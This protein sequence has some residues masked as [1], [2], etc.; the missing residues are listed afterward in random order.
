VNG[1]HPLFLSLPL[2]IRCCCC[3]PSSPHTHRCH[4][5]T[6]GTYLAPYMDHVN[7]ILN[8]SRRSPLGQV[9]PDNQQR[10]LQHQ[11]HLLLP[12]VLLHQVG[13][14][15]AKHPQF[16][17]LSLL[18]A[19][20][21][22]GALGVWQ[23]PLPRKRGDP[24][25]SS[26]PW[27]QKHPPAEVLEEVLP[28][29]SKV[30]AGLEQHLGSDAGAAAGS[31]SS[32]SCCS[33]K[34]SSSVGVRAMPNL[35]E[36]LCQLVAPCVWLEP[37]LEG[38]IGTAAALDVFIEAA[39][40]KPG[41]AGPG[42][43][44]LRALK[45]TDFPDPGRGVFT[46]SCLPGKAV[47]VM[48]CLERYLRHLAA[49][50]A[51]QSPE[52][53]KAA[54]FSINGLLESTELKQDQPLGGDLGL[55]PNGPLVTVAAAAGPGSATYQQLQSLLATLLK[56]G[57]YISS[58]SGWPGAR[59]IA[60]VC[61]T[62]AA[63]A[64]RALLADSGRGVQ[65]A[66]AATAATAAASSSGS[67][68]SSSS[69]LQGV[70]YLGLEQY[71]GFKPG[72]I[73]EGWNPL[74]QLSSLVILGRCYIMFAQQLQQEG[75]ILLKA[76]A[77]KQQRQPL[78]VVTESVT[79]FGLRNLCFTSI[80][81]LQPAGNGMTQLELQVSHTEIPWLQN[82]EV[83]AELTAA[84]YD[85]QGLLTALQQLSAAGKAAS[86]S[87]DGEEPLKLL[88]K[89]LQAA[90]QALNTLP[91]PVSCN[92][93]GCSSVAGPSE[94]QLVGG[95]GCLCAGCRTA[96]YCSKVCQK[97]HWKQHKPVCKARGAAAAGG[98]SSKAAAGSAAAAAGGGAAA[99]GG[100][101][102]EFHDAR[103]DEFVDASS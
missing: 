80:I 77:G 97:Q 58:S 17:E 75:P 25:P 37:V 66:A 14:L 59:S 33:G 92:N 20:I 56:T 74:D 94:V 90:G 91:S 89:Q 7:F 10:L 98:G 13:G 19:Q 36:V 16:A 41:L 81:C 85:P 72:S 49:T 47:E 24:L 60:S 101:D 83:S 45:L 1:F 34:G 38:A 32:C 48:V 42:G 69:A 21:G 88:V 50:A 51:Q 87:T 99:A 4:A 82:P 26:D 54:L 65:A 73:A 62:T 67:G 12:V 64:A 86:A 39:L 35:T 103:S 84:C 3:H 44:D 31:S 27:L 52:M 93:P 55:A 22:R 46:V 63:V 102:D 96:R 30:F 53:A 71:D 76:Q 79:S 78:S 5:H 43:L 11:L 57:Q 2:S 29:M 61:A 100:G 68:S 70:T 9:M 15:P 8:A 28:I 23:L 40:S 6:Y 95:R 18:A